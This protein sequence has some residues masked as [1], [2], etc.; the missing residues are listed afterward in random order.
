MKHKNHIQNWTSLDLVL[1][2]GK[3]IF[4]GSFTKYI[5]FLNWVRC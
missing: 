3:C 5:G 1:V 2:I 4:V